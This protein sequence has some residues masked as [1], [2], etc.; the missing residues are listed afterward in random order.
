MVEIIR[1]DT[2]ELVK[3]AKE[4]FVEYA[5][6]LGVDLLFQNFDQELAELPGDYTPPSGCLF[7]AFADRKIAGCVALRPLN[8]EVCEM[9]RLYV[10]SDFRGRGIGRLLTERAIAE[11]KAIG[12]RKM[13][14]DTLP[15]MVEAIALYRSLGF[16]EIPP[17]RYNPIP[18]AKYFELIL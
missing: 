9:K 6:G 2:E 8:N 11:A 16:N 15:S 18:G 17:Y 7:L 14:L 12:Y 4:L 5:R 10:R 13:R 3:I 1:A